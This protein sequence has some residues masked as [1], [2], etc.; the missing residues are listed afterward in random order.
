MTEQRIIGGR[1]VYGVR[2]EPREQGKTCP[3]CG[4]PRHPDAKRCRW[5][6]LGLAQKR[7]SVRV[8]ARKLVARVQA[9]QRLVLWPNAEMGPDEFEDALRDA[10]REWRKANSQ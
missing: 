6:H 8:E 4:R 2:L 7:H 1:R 9:G 10:L 3:D 5:C